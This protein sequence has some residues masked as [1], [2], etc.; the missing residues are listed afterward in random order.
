[1][2]FRFAAFLGFLCP[3][4]SRS[5]IPDNGAAIFSFSLSPTVCLRS[6]LFSA[7]RDDNRFTSQ[8]GGQV[9]DSPGIWVTT[10]W[11]PRCQTLQTEPLVV[12]VDGMTCCGTQKP[13][14][15]TSETS[16]RLLT[17]SNRSGVSVPS[18]LSKSHQRA[19]DG[20]GTYSQPETK[21]SRHPRSEMHEPIIN[22]PPHLHG[23]S[24]LSALSPP[25]RTCLPRRLGQSPAHAR[26]KGFEQIS[27][28][29]WKSRG[30]WDLGSFLLPNQR[31]SL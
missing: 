15:P 11:F 22:F 29:G 13:S 5:K 24:I 16:C 20:L 30:L 18:S 8:R 27:R 7:G 4:C 14:I 12:L 2:I 28:L 6:H 25:T 17:R 19:P 1:M 9:T 23:S 26:G 31:D 21:H 3:G 10:R